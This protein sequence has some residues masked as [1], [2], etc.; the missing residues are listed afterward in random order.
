MIHFQ[1][2]INIFEEKQLREQSRNEKD[3]GVNKPIVLALVRNVKENNHNLG[4]LTKLNLNQLKF[5]VASDLKLI[6]VEK[7]LTHGS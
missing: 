6:N 1:E 7:F 3:S 2:I 5:F 4:E